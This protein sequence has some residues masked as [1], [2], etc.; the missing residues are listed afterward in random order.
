VRLGTKAFSLEN[1]L[2]LKFQCFGIF[3]N[4]LKKLKPKAN[5]HYKKNQYLQL[6]FVIKKCHLHWINSGDPAIVD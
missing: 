3:F 2:K 4:S 1:N 5:F 6:V